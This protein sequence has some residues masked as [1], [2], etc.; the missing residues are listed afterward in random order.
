L[1]DVFLQEQPNKKDLSYLW[2]FALLFVVFFVAFLQSPGLVS[3]G[4]I[5]IPLFLFTLIILGL[6]IRKVHPFSEVIFGVPGY[7]ANSLLSSSQKSGVERLYLSLAVGLGIGG[8]LMS[9]YLTNGAAGSI[10]LP[11]TLSISIGTTSGYIILAVLTIFGPEIE[12]MFRASVLVPTAAGF[13]GYGKE[14]S[15]II[16]MAGIL[17]AFATSVPYYGYL[18]IAIG[19]FFVLTQRYA[20]NLLTSTNA[21]HIFALGIAAI[22]LGIFHIYAYGANVSLIYGAVLL[23]AFFDLVNW[24]MQDTIASRM[25]HSVNNAIVGG[26]TLGL[27]FGIYVGLFG[28]ALYA[29]IIISVWKSGSRSRFGNFGVVGA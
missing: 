23:F 27:P 4:S 3:Y 25:M 10:F 19:V 17:V 29:I 2:F 24:F 9:Q 15:L 12:E 8:F 28:T 6:A 20:D 21:S 11:A 13:I 22:I 5:Y 16:I 14:Y 18:L 1:S 26:S 7:L